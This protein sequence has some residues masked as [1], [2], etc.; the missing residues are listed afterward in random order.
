ML[1]PDRYVDGRNYGSMMRFVNHSCSPNCTTEKWSINGETRIAVVAL[2]DIQAHEEITFDYQWKA[3]RGK[4]TRYI[5]YK[6]Y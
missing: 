4:S 5:F 6:N 3:L 2:R 1:E